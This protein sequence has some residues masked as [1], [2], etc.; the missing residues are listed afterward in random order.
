MVGIVQRKDMASF[1]LSSS[2]LIFTT[3]CY[4]VRIIMIFAPF[5]QVSENVKRIGILCKTTALLLVGC[6]CWPVQISSKI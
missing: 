4:A 1:P 6:A 3:H 5:G 2:H